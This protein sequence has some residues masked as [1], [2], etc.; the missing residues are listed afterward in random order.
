MKLNFT[1]INTPLCVIKTRQDMHQTN[2][3]LRIG[4]LTRS[5][6]IHYKHTFTEGICCTT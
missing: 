6:I 5:D 3:Q 4:G 1:Q 2:T